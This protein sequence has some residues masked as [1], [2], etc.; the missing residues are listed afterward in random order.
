MVPG[1]PGLLSAVLLALLF[2]GGVGVSPA[3]RP[4]RVITPD[5]SPIWIDPQFSFFFDSPSL[6]LMLR[7][8]HSGSI[9]Y[10]LRIWIFDDHSRLKGTLDY[11]TF[12]A[13]GRDTRGRVFVP[14]APGV[15]I[16]DRVVVTISAAASGRVR[17]SLRQ[18][19]ADQL[20]AARTAAKD[21][22]GRLSMDRAESGS[23]AWSCPCECPVVETLCNGRC[24]ATGG[25][26][27]VC[28]RTF[29]GGCAASCTCK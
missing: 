9:N 29:D 28:T 27:S 2:A 16:R 4:A 3:D 25:A 24:A 11:C 8:E 21:S 13:L 19:E 15:I 14:L 20:E 23:D 22:P 1:R 5:G 6:S 7:N 26:T 18:N 12:D 10:A 17:W